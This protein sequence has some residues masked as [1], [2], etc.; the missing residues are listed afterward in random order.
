MKALGEYTKAGAALAGNYTNQRGKRGEWGMRSG[1]GAVYNQ[2]AVQLKTDVA[3]LAKIAIGE[4]VDRYNQAA[5]KAEKSPT[6][7]KRLLN[8]AGQYATAASEIAGKFP[9]PQLAPVQKA[10]DG[11]VRRSQNSGKDGNC[12]DISKSEIFQG[13]GRDL[14]PVFGIHSPA[15]CQVTLHWPTFLRKRSIKNI[16]RF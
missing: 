4:A 15:R 14:N 2:L 5:V 9:L 11:M 1:L 10:A 12:S 7:A 3:G 8:E 6:E 13:Q 16:N